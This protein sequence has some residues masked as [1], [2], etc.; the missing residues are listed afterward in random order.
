VIGSCP[1]DRL[2]DWGWVCIYIYR[3][4]RNQWQLVLGK[5]G[6][7]EGRDC[8]NNRLTATRSCDRDKGVAGE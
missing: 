6:G 2:V 3:K 7:G 5:L 4:L 1:V 8:I